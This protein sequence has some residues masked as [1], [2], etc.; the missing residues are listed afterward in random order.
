MTKQDITNVSIQFQGTAKGKRKVQFQFERIEQLIGHTLLTPEQV[1]E[2]E[3]KAYQLVDSKGF[4]NVSRASLVVN[5][6][7]NEGDMTFIMV[8]AKQRILINRGV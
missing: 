5:H 3:R 7:H 6:G 4:K 8:L 2:F 1:I